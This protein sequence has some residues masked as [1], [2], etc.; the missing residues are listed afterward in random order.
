LKIEQVLFLQIFNF[1]RKIE[2]N[3]GIFTSGIFVNM[4]DSIQQQGA[5]FRRRR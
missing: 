4:A 5:T 3:L 1:F 2:S